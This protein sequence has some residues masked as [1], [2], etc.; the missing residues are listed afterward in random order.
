[1]AESQS[2][3]G[4]TIS[5]YRIVEKVGG[6]GMGVVYKA[7]DTRLERFVALKF[8]P[9]DLARD[10]QALERFRREAKAA[11]ALNHPNI[12]TIHETA[13]MEEKPFIVMEFLEGQTLKQCITGQ[14][15]E[16]ERLWEVAIEMADALD[17]AHAK[18]IIHRDIKPANIFVTD[19]GHAKILDF[20]LAKVTGKAEGGSNSATSLDTMSGDN[21]QL[22]GPGSA[23]GTV[24][25]MSPEQ[26][27]GKVLDPRT[28]LFSLGIVIYEMATGSLPFRGD[29]SGAI[30]NEILNREPVPPVR[31]N[32]GISPEL[33]HVIQKGLEKDRDL[34]YQ[35]A[36]EMRADLRRAKRSSE[37]SKLQV[38]VS[39]EVKA[40]PDRKLLRTTAILLATVAV[41]F[42][43]W[44]TY[45][46]WRHH[47][48]SSASFTPVQFT[49][50]PG[51]A[52]F[53]ALSPDG[54]QIAFVWT[55]DPADNKPGVDIYT[56]KI[57]SENLQCVTNRPSLY[58]P[59]KW[60]PDG[61]QIAYQRL[62]KG[63]SGIYVIP[64]EGGS[65]KKLRSTHGSLD[66]S[67]H[68][69]WAPDGKSIA[70]ADSSVSGG[71]KKV[72]ILSLE[73]LQSKQIE[74]N[75][76]CEE[77][78]L[79]T[80]SPD[81]K[82]LAYVCFPTSGD[83]ALSVATSAGAGPRVIKEFP[84]YFHGMAWR[85]DSKSLLFFSS[86]R[87]DR[88]LRD[89]AIADGSVQDIQFG[90]GGN[91]PTVAPTGDRLAYAVEVGGNNEIFRADLLHP[92]TP[93]IK[94]I[95]STRE[96]MVPA[97]SPDGKH[98]A[99]A[100]NRGG[101]NE[102]WMSDSDGTN[103]VQ[104]TNLKNP[105]TGTPSWSPDSRK[106]VFDSR[107]AA[108]EGK[109][110]ADVYIVDIVE[111]APRKLLTGT[112]EGA[113]PDWSHD[114]KWI[115]FL[116]GGDEA[117]G[118]R[119]YRVAPE[120]GRAEAVTLARGYGPQESIDGQ[121]LYFTVHSGSTT[122]LQ[123]ASLNPTGTEARV[124]GMPPLRFGMAWTVARDGIYFVAAD[125]PKV[126]SYYDFA[127]K[128]V[129]LILK[130]YGYINYGLSVSPDGRYVIFAQMSRNQS[131]IMLVNNFR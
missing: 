61:K 42:L 115:F 16:M 126:L 83:F 81:G 6:G 7:E 117:R 107:T 13:E 51:W 69:S 98:I 3:I 4:Q 22:T 65:E 129:R 11:S 120:G 125:D 52:A 124:E 26:V 67:M 19:R 39:Q 44:F 128:K 76:K 50:L 31:L 106:I 35:S 45:L 37:S 25:Y 92:Q 112:P 48:S 47:P 63:E 17:A 109:S 64:A 34:R 10:R 93:P 87:S 53:P 55:G 23:L 130:A 102:I 95:S 121:S 32:T 21:N 88:Q 86:T 113:V 9:A 78:A 73:T 123:A 38:P 18:G 77:E 71:H 68:I 62:A 85:N 54:T 57:G 96:Q 8:L 118:E 46:R 40:K 103:L 41:V 114:G 1:M 79:P 36:A 84:G 131:D 110:H 66:R 5:H 99:F 58:G 105:T 33:E 29:T 75:E 20:G 30:F 116:G 24:S 14:P 80:F 43:A 91:M 72:Q 119:I 15:M 127:T 12:C 82:Q 27:L 97:Y 108:V 60:S 28:D 100:S 101:N 89:L 122:I 74:Q 104:L 70:F 56:K 94:L 2:L 59:P 90:Q 111:R 49:A